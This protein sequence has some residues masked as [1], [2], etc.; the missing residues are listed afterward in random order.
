VTSLGNI[1]GRKDF[2]VVLKGD[3]VDSVDRKGGELKVGESLILTTARVM[4]KT[5]HHR[6]DDTRGGWFRRITV[7]GL[8]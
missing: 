8:N 3:R 4:Q 6:F 5:N 2:D 1:Q 7:A